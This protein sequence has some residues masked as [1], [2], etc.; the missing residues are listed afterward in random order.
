MLVG[1]SKKLCTLLP[2]HFQLWLQAK[3]YR[4]KIR[5]GQFSSPEPEYTLLEDWIRPGDSVIDIGANVGHYTLRLSKLVGSGGRVYAF[6]PVPET[7]ALLVGNLNFAR[8]DNVSFFNC[9]A[10]EQSFTA[11]MGIPVHN[12]GLP[13][14]YEARLN[15]SFASKTSNVICIAIDGLNILDK[16]KLV[17]VDVEGHELEAIKGM[18][19]LVT[20]YR[21]ILIVEGY[22][23][24]IASLLGD[25]NYSIGRFPNSPNRVFF[26]K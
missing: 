4:N 14:L 21:P 2:R 19:E 3:V 11:Q 18:I 1:L 20:R 25:M 17:K 16:V 5:F 7:F 9:G 23:V 12:T 15:P 6:E 26:P 22:D 13:N 10:S 24:R 8:A